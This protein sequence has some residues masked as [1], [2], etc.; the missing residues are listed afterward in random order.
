MFWY[1]SWLWPVNSW[2]CWLFAGTSGGFP[3]CL[4]C[5]RSPATYPYHNMI[6]GKF[7]SFSKRI[8]VPMVLLGRKALLIRIEN[9]RKRPKHT[10]VP[11]DR[12]DVSYQP[13]GKGNLGLGLISFEVVNFRSLSL[14]RISLKFYI[15]FAVEVQ[16]SVVSFCLLL[17]Y[18]SNSEFSPNFSH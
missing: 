12:D 1:V 7:T 5:S 17:V 4:D 6:Y 10:T 15:W 14:W 16:T 11:E 9:W 18:F 8:M 2:F 13:T 3:Q